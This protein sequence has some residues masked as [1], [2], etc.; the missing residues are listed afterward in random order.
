MKQNIKSDFTESQTLR[1]G[2]PNLICA[3]LWQTDTLKDKTPLT[4]HIT[5][6]C[7]H[8]GRPGAPFVDTSKLKESEMVES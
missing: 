3:V 6:P 8:W 1:K 5:N 7:C 4:K 2:L